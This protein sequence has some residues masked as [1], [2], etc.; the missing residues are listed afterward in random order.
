M[1]YQ[2][3]LLVDIR[4]EVCNRYFSAIQKNRLHTSPNNRIWN[5][6]L[7]EHAAD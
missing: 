1:Y 5:E 2:I 7:H 6:Y 4:I 3:E